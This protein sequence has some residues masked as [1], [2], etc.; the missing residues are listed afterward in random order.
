MLGNVPGASAPKE[1]TMSR[2]SRR[3]AFTLIELLVVVAII[4]LLI[5]IL[6]PALQA[7]K[8]EASRTK[9]LA[10][11]RAIASASNTY[12]AE[13]EFDLVIPIQQ[14]LQYQTHGEGFAS[15]VWVVRTMMPYSY[16]GRTAQFPWGG[17]QLPRWGADS[18]PLNVHMYTS[19]L[20]GEE[21]KVLE[22]FHCPSD[23]G[24]PEEDPNLEL[25]HD[26]PRGQRGIPCYDLTGNSYR[27]NP[28]GVFWPSGQNSR[29]YFTIGA[30]GHAVD[31]LPDPSRLMLYCEPIFY[32]MTFA[33][34]DMQYDPSLSPLLGWH[35]RVMEDNVA[36]VDGSASATKA[37]GLQVWADSTL[38]GM[39]FSPDHADAH[40]WLRRGETW[41]S[42]CYPAPG[43]WIPILNSDGTVA[44]TS[45]G[46][47]PDNAFS[48]QMWGWPF[49]GYRT[50]KPN[51]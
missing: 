10:N 48:G 19:K 7:A 23:I 6:L 31:T 13:D 49:R 12:A 50:L 21:A 33:L 14:Q 44:S 16:G 45:V 1:M 38:E 30:Q 9:C 3:T 2:L 51:F 24:Y 29:G 43:V 11:L 4:A 27:T 28:A 36:F 37:A 8:E 35:R 20:W 41:R 25:I 34:E 26:C 47:R 32:N 39:T 17:N 40:D 42:D 5:A 15:G 18:R 22:L 46:T